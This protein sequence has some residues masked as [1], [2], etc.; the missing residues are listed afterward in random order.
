[1]SYF[2]TR[3]DI[4]NA[5]LFSNR[6]VISEINALRQKEQAFDS[7][8]KTSIKRVD[9]YYTEA[10][11]WIK[12]TEKRTSVSISTFNE[13]LFETEP[14]HRFYESTIKILYILS[15]TGFFLWDRGVTKLNCKITFEN[16][17]L[18]I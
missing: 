12:W 9:I 8:S 15:E 17:V 10:F 18:K 2:F 7:E 14:V 3:I 4:S 1:M 13:I 16:Q 5:S 11:V 6:Q